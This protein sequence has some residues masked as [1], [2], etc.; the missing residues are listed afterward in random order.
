MTHA[1]HVITVSNLTRQTVIDHYG[2]GLYEILNSQESLA[3]KLIR[4]LDGME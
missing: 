4:E 2:D 3:K 1:D